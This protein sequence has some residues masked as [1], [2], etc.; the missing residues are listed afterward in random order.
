MDSCI[1]GY[2]L[3]GLLRKRWADERVGVMITVAYYCGL[4]LWLTTVAYYC[5]KT[6]W[7]SRQGGRASA[8]VSLYWPFFS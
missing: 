2:S 1:V 4:L 8:R 6:K 7:G 5:G 3:K